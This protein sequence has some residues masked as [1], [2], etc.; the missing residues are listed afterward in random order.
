MTKFGT[1]PNN[2]DCFFDTNLNITVGIHRILKVDARF[3]SRI[4]IRTFPPH[5]GKLGKALFCY[6]SPE[7]SEFYLRTFG[8]RNILELW[9]YVVGKLNDSFRLAQN[10]F[11]LRR[12]DE[13]YHTGKVHI[14]AVYTEER[15]VS[16]RN[17]KRRK[18][19]QRKK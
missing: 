12:Q 15:T 11:H 9:L 6:K 4:I 3:H 17:K 10:V 13:G 1:R 18:K 2:L 5:F 14:L 7:R 16:W 8:V 19:K